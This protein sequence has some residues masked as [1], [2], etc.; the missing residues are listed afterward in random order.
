MAIVLLPLR[1]LFVRVGVSLRFFES[2]LILDDSDATESSSSFS[3]L[4]L[5]AFFG[6]NLSSFSAIIL[7]SRFHTDLHLFSEMAMRRLHNLWEFKNL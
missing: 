7:F 5:V 4:L 6:L 3:S 1:F 2:S